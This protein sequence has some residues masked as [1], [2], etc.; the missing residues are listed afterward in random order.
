ML[1]VALGACAGTTGQRL[2]V[3]PKQSAA[4]PAQGAG[5]AQGPIQGP[6][7]SPAQG[8][9]QS[10]DLD[11]L[12]YGSPAMTA[13]AQAIVPAP[14]AA[15]ARAIVPVAAPGPGVVV[16]V[17][18]P[19]EAFE[20]DPPYLLDTGDR[21]RIVVFGQDGLSNS[22]VVDASGA[23]TMPL[24]KAVPARGLTTQ[25]LSHTI[26]ERLRRG[27]VREP[28]CTA[29]QMVGWSLWVHSTR[30]RTWAGMCR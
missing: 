17:V 22:Y 7:R 12:A 8:P 25:Q 30:W 16:P 21:L 1:A 27:F 18:A 6:T 11:S 24:I 26:A 28:K 2:A 20:G 15:Q 5:S 10:A 23:I 3:V 19:A 13:R 14:T 4:T 29:S 9:T